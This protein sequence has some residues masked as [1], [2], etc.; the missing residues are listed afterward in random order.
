[1]RAIWAT[2]ALLLVPATAQAECVPLEIPMATDTITTAIA[3]GTHVATEVNPIGFAGATAV[4]LAYYIATPQVVTPEEQ[5]T[6][7]HL[8][9]S[10]LW[11]ATANNLLV[12]GFAAM[13]IVAVPVGIL[14]GV[15]Y[16]TTQ[17]TCR[18][19]GPTAVE[20]ESDPVPVERPHSTPN[21][22]AENK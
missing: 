6:L 5:R 7:D 3:L 12:L 19:T 15:V 10:A 22:P 11:A 4:K 14:A 1:M 17:E 8:M 13:P 20:T 18:L 2:L 9:A 16:Y 21:I